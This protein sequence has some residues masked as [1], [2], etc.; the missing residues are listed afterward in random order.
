MIETVDAM[1]LL[2]IDIDY[3]WALERKGKIP[4]AEKE[5]ASVVKDAEK[6]F[7]E[8]QE[9]REVA[10]LLKQNPI[11]CSGCFDKEIML[12]V[13]V[14]RDIGRGDWPAFQRSNHTYFEYF[15]RLAHNIEYPLIVF[16]DEQTTSHLKVMM[17]DLHPKHIIFID[18]HSVNS[19]F[20][21]HVELHMEIIGSEFYR[22]KIPDHRKNKAEHNH[23][24]YT[25]LMASKMDY[26]RDARRRYPGYSYYTFIDFGY[27]RKDCVVP[28]QIDVSR[29][30]SNKIMFTV[31][32]L[33]DIGRGRELSREQ[34]L[35]T[36]V[37]F[38][39]GGTFI[40]PNMLM[41]SF[42][43][44][45][46]EELDRYHNDYLVD[47][48]QSLIYRIMVETPMLFA[49]VRPF[50]WMALFNTYLNKDLVIEV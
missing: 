3:A 15:L 42:Y 41:D 27:T 4:S 7:L 12:F 38:A 36:D 50:Q 31:L 48:D 25:V 2:S 34:L 1:A 22:S 29:L 21:R 17:G 24:D 11:D 45:W 28:K 49:Y 35:S 39:Q 9:L 16:A 10:K 6:S 20:E 40:I 26:M 8:F 32:A 43:R 33:P 13:T 30:L 44:L 46:F 5:I 18:I 23:G 19:A 14:F 37:I 47:D